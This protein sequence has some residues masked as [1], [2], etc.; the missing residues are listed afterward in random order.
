MEE[1]KHIKSINIQN[2]KCFDNFS[3]E[4][5]GLYNIILGDNNVGKTSF[6]ESLL[7]D[8]NIVQSISNLQG[9]LYY[10]RIG[11]DNEL[12]TSI[13]NPFSFFIKNNA[14]ERGVFV[15]LS[16]TNNIVCNYRYEVEKLE[17]LS[18][19]ERT[20]FYDSINFSSNEKEILKVTLQN[21]HVEYRS[22]S[23]DENLEGHELNMPIILPS[24]LYGKDLIQFYADNFTSSKLKKNSL[25]EQ[26]KVILPTITDIE[27][28]YTGNIPIIGIWLSNVDSLLPLPMFGDGTVRLFRMIMEIAMCK[29]KYLCIDEIDTGIHYSRYKD[30]SRIVLQTAKAN[31]VQLFIS[32]HNNEFLKSFKEVLE[33][34][35]FATYQDETKCFT[36][37]KLP[38]ESIKAY[39]YDFEE[40]EFAI[41]QENELR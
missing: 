5:F 12:N 19:A 21:K 16:F 32:T 11:F 14:I 39:K 2:F 6:L 36:L 3:A 27:L 25:I 9:I 37:K 34:K 15:K 41:E 33:D 10:K 23:V 1:V 30:F 26:I 13:I 29:N 40:F 28:T 22:F 8:E 17:N 7:F 24:I 35:D 18:N 31:N 38:D 4:G 20:K